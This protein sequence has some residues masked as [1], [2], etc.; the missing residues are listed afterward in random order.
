MGITVCIC[1]HAMHQWSLGNGL[2]RLQLQEGHSRTH[3]ADSPHWHSGKG[4][5]SPHRHVGGGRTW[6]HCCCVIRPRCTMSAGVMGASWSSALVV[7]VITFCA[8]LQA[9]TSVCQPLCGS[10]FTQGTCPSGSQQQGCP[11]PA[12]LRL[13]PGQASAL[14]Q[15]GG[16]V[17]RGSTARVASCRQTWI[18]SGCP[19][20]AWCC[21]LWFLRSP[22]GKLLPQYW[23]CPAL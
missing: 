21:H 17:L 18:S 20:F 1:D 5:L 8:S 14:L 7:G 6:S 19:I 15:Q 4:M 23:R 12:G 13:R 3:H 9:S 22:S 2:V 16:C 10:W 11:V